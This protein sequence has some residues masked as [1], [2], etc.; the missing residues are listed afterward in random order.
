MLCYNHYNSALTFVQLFKTFIINLLIISNYA[1]IL[2]FFS[3]IITYIFFSSGASICITYFDTTTNFEHVKNVYVSRSDSAKDCIKKALNSLPILEN[4]DL[5]SSVNTNSD[6]TKNS[7]TSSNSSDGSKS[8]DNNTHT[9]N[10]SSAANTPSKAI[11]AY[12]KGEDEGG[13]GPEGSGE[14]QNGGQAAKSA[15]YQL[16]V[17]TKFDESPYPLIGKFFF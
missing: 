15:D 3:Q 5:G 4:G 9:S 16:W 13:G 12:K 10:N 8:C 17:K 14:D 11:S 6:N 1:L 7:V 2:I